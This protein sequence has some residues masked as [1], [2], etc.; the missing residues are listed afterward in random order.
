M[1]E[2]YLLYGTV[3]YQDS[4]H[5]HIWR[6]IVVCLNESKRTDQPKTEKR[7][8]IKKAPAPKTKHSH[9]CCHCLEFCESPQNGNCHIQ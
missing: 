4:F 9:I 6:S 5:K 1:I 3:T 8:D 2:M 7:K